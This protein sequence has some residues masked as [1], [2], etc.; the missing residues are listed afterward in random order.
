METKK[1]SLKPQDLVKIIHAGKECGVAEI[2][3]QD[4][5]ITFTH[6]EE[7]HTQQ[8]GIPFELKPSKSDADLDELMLSNPLA[9]EEITSNGIEAEED[10]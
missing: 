2:A 5:K 7:T 4:L 8:A 3:W 10:S 6:K 1:N 9:Y